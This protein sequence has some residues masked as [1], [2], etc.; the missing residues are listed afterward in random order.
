MCNIYDFIV[1]IKRTKT[2]MRKLKP[3]EEGREEKGNMKG[4]T[5]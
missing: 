3:R 1:K 4:I 5:R 2:S